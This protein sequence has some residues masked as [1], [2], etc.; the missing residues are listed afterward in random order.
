MEASRGRNSILNA[1]ITKWSIGRILTSCSLTFPNDLSTQKSTYSK[2][3]TLNEWVDEIHDKSHD[4]SGLRVPVRQRIFWPLHLD[5]LHLP[6]CWHFALEWG[7]WI[8]FLP[9]FL[10]EGMR[11]T[12]GRVQAFRG[13]GYNRQ[14]VC[15]DY[16]TS[17]SKL[18][19]I[20]LQESPNWD[21]VQCISVSSSCTEDLGKHQ[22]LCTEQM[23]N[24]QFKIT[25]S[26]DHLCSL[27]I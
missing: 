23:L 15:W 6:Q 21:L 20:S 10:P 3:R 17:P 1:L 27:E 18:P 2:G 8:S 9:S 26:R 7:S 24:L 5:W 19:P 11:G 13:F 22:Q 16:A 4:K 25:S 14:R 12:G